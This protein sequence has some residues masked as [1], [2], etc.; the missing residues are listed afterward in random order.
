MRH[1]YGCMYDF[2]FNFYRNNIFVLILLFW[3]ACWSA[4]FVCHAI[5]YSPLVTIQQ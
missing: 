3:L 4:T 2:C 1:V 5:C